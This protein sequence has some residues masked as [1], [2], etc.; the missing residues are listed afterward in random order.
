MAKI[1]RGFE[2]DGDRYFY[3]FEACHFKLGWAQVDSNQDAW[4]YGNWINPLTL[5][6]MSY[7][8]GDTTLTECED[9][10]SFVKEVRE[11]CDWQKS[12]GYFIGVDCMCSAEIEAAFDRLG[13]GEYL[14]GRVAA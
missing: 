13:L 6:L 5:K 4:Y 10:A 2:N 7:A 8:E 12:A 1:T 9:D 3:D 14:H 11:H